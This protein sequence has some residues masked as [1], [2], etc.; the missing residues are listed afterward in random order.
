[1]CVQLIPQKKGCAQKIVRIRKQE[2]PETRPTLIISAPFPPQ[3][4]PKG[5]MK[6]LRLACTIIEFVR[7]TELEAC[8]PNRYS[9]SQSSCC[10]R[11][12]VACDTRGSARKRK[13]CFQFKIFWPNDMTLI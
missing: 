12:T 8:E 6:A 3:L 9:G 7:T 2:R 4:A 13:D 5:V 11:S 10:I 1:M